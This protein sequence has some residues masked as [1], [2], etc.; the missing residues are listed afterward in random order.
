MSTVHPTSQLG[1]AKGTNEL[2]NKA[3]GEYEPKVLSQLREVI[4]PLEPLNVVEIG[5]GT[6]LFARALLAH[7]DWK[8]VRNYRA[9][10]PSEG[11][12]ETFTKYTQD[13][14]VVLSEGTFAETGVEDSWA[15]LI[16]IAQAFHWC[17]EHEPAAAEFARILKP[18]GVLALVWVHEGRETAPWLEQFR[19]R[20]D[21]DERGAPST[22]TGFWRQL[23]NASSYTKAFTPPEEAGFTYNFPDTIDGLISRGLSSSRIVVLTDSEKEVLIEDV[24]A[25]IQRGEGKVW[26]DEEKGIFEHPHRV[27]IVVSRRV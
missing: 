9:I 26:I 22:R 1:F 11:M 17:L 15:D 23:F 2:Y 8:T 19:K 13:H 7:E 3:R 4:Q 5:A 20:V 10:D 18:G 27:V 14:R 16:V 6:G 21:R 12:R 25:I 24:Q